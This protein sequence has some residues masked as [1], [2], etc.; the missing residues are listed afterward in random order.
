M[1]P[2]ETKDVCRVCFRNYIDDTLV[3]FYP[4]YN[5][6]M[7]SVC[8]KAGINSAAHIDRL[9]DIEILLT[10]SNRLKEEIKQ[11]ALLTWRFD[12][13]KYIDAY[14]RYVNPIYQHIIE[15]DQRDITLIKNK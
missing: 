3:I 12:G 6:N 11:K 1:P 7:C 4:I 10:D 5:S 13:Y 9:D 14:F 8:Y 15:Y 2:S